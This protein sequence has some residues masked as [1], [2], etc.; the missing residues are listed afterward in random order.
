MTSK[1]VLASKQV[2]VM[3]INTASIGQRALCGTLKLESERSY[4][5]Q[6]GGEFRISLGRKR[7]IE[8]L[9]TKARRLCDL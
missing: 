8:A 9:T 3:T 4:H 2:L 7:L 1:Q 6:H 5:L